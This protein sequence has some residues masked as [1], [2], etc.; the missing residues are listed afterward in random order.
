MVSLRGALP[1]LLTGTSGVALLAFGVGGLSGMEPQ[2]RQAARTVQLEQTAPGTHH[3][4]ADCPW[5][6][7]RGRAAD[8]V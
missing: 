6:H 5:Q 3:Q 7:D 1:L 2:I 4:F 8:E